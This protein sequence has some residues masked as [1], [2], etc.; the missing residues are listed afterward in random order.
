MERYELSVQKRHS[1]KTLGNSNAVTMA[2][3]AKI[4]GRT[5]REIGLGRNA[6]NRRIIKVIHFVSVF[7]NNNFI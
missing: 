4:D 5:V 1:N 2:E 7:I 3:S 6:V